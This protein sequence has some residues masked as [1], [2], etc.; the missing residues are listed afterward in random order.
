MSTS[1]RSS[2][3]RSGPHADLGTNLGTNPGADKGADKGADQG[4]DQGAH[5]VANPGADSRSS[6]HR[7]DAGPGIEPE[8]T[9]PRI[10]V[11]RWDLPPDGATAEYLLAAFPAVGEALAGRTRVGMILGLQRIGVPRPAAREVFRE[12]M[13]TLSPSLRGVAVLVSPNPLAGLLSG[14]G[15]YLMGNIP[16]SMSV[17]RDES[18]ALRWLKAGGSAGKEVAS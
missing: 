5:N 16:V 2:R 18:K 12:Q 14:I 11:M 1:S 10:D 3:E 8:L 13:R 9:W 7:S 17:A 4:A 15:V 6:P